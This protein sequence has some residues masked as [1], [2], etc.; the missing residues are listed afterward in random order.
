MLKTDWIFRQTSSTD[1][2]DLFRLI[3][4]LNSNETDGLFSTQLVKTLVDEFWELYRVSI[5]VAV[6]M[7]F[8]LYALC[9]I[10]YFTLHS[11][12]VMD[13]AKQADPSERENEGLFEWL[14]KQVV[15]ALT[16]FMLAFEYFQ[17]IDYGWAYFKERTNWVDMISSIMVLL[18]AIKNDFYPEDFYTLERE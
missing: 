9:C 13:N 4:T 7:P 14:N 2:N 8:M 18:M 1:Q 15:Y 10:L 11:M 3:K 16:F 5:F 6:F 12:R 17:V